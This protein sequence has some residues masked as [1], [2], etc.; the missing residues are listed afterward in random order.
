MYLAFRPRRKSGI[1]YTCHTVEHFR[2]ITPFGTFTSVRPIR[3]ALS[4]G[5][6]S[7]LLDEALIVRMVAMIIVPTR[8]VHVRY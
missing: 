1:S 6:L 5:L 3:G 8:F 7:F 2:V 4:L